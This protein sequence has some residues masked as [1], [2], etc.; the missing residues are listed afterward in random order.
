[1]PVCHADNYVRDISKGEANALSPSSDEGIEHRGVHAF[2]HV[3]VHEDQR[4]PL[5]PR[6]CSCALCSSR[7]F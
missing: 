6:F 1:M 4:A 5:L 2:R 3:E 7:I